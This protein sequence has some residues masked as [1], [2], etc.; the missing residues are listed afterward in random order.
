MNWRGDC[1]STATSPALAINRAVF[2]NGAW[3]TPAAS[4]SK[5]GWLPAIRGAGLCG[6]FMGLAFI[7]P[8]GFSNGFS[9]SLERLDEVNG[10]GQS[11]E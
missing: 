9:N 7:D 2:H 11:C 5:F 6:M 4:K 8:L 3:A 10:P 1:F